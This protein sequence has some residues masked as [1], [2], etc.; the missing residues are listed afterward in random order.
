MMGSEK[1]SIV[2]QLAG[3]L[4]GLMKLQ[5]ADFKTK[6]A[7]TTAI[8][9]SKIQYLLPLYGGAPN[10]GL[11]STAAKSCKIRVWVQKLLLVNPKAT[12]NMSMAFCKT[13]R[14]LL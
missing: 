1:S 3:R 12:D 6:L 5:Q 4:N 13:T 2:C 8:I 9:Q 14:I 11:T 10:G 7:V